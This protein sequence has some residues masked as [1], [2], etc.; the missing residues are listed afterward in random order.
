LSH[1]I[2]QRP[3]DITTRIGLTQYRST[4]ISIRL[5]LQMTLAENARFAYACQLTQQE[6]A[7]LGLTSYAGRYPPLDLVSHNPPAQFWQPEIWL[8]Q[9]QRISGLSRWNLTAFT[10]YCPD[11]LAGDTSAVQERHGGAWRKSWRIPLIFACTTHQRLLTTTCPA[12]HNLAHS[13]PGA[14][15]LITRPSELLHPAQCRAVVGAMT[16]NRRGIQ[17]CGHR[18]DRGQPAGPEISGDLLTLQRRFDQLLHASTPGNQTSLGQP[19]STANYF[20]DLRLITIL[21]NL[22]W[23]LARH[24]TTASLAPAI[25]EETEQQQRKLHDQRRQGR[26]P[27]LIVRYNAPPHE[28][29]PC[30]ALFDT[31]VRILNLTDPAAFA[32]TLESLVANAF[33]DSRWV[34]FFGDAKQH[35]SPAMRAALTK[36]E[37]KRDA[38]RPP[39]RRGKNQGAK[40]ARWREDLIARPP[41]PD[42]RFDYRHV[43][44]YLTDDWYD[45]H[46]SWSANSIG[47]ST[48]RHAA[49]ICLVQTTRAT[50]L[51]HASAQLG[52]HERITRSALYSTDRWARENS[53]IK[54][55]TTALNAIANELNST[56]NLIDYAARRE[57]LRTWT[58]PPADWD[59]LTTEIRDKLGHGRLSSDWE[60]RHSQVGT[61]LIWAQITQGH[62]RHAPLWLAQPAGHGHRQLTLDITQTI[63]PEP[64]QHDQ[65]LHNAP[66]RPQHLRQATGIPDRQRRDDR[67]RPTPTLLLAAIRECGQ[68]VLKV[69]TDGQRRCR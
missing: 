2:E 29:L 11:C 48:L 55:F 37:A 36:I 33:Q 41:R 40:V 9:T 20:L 44:A 25:D 69:L 65:A 56:P 53:I 16:G 5:L 32:S 3:I 43:P 45:R 8:R 7:A 1:R 68:A 28:A 46:F 10:R 30:A 64:A 18:L 21:A 67:Q 58:I 66:A 57:A 49:A 14:P 22:T 26:N 54:R 34:K 17:T 60:K 19:V 15:G 23:P 62:R 42:C 50:S 27:S 47:K 61:I 35:C 12:C 13:G 24:F 31:A 4:K 51:R 38:Q 63:G 59:E 39:N 6:T 52:L